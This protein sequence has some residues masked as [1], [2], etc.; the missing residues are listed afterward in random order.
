MNK[1]KKLAMLFLI[2]ASL[3]GAFLLTN[4]AADLQGKDKNSELFKIE[5]LEYGKVNATKYSTTE[6]NEIVDVPGDRDSILVKPLISNASKVEISSPTDGL[7]EYQGNLVW[8]INILDKSK[9]IFTVSVTSETQTKK[10]L[11]LQSND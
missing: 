7:L 6:V 10:H 1:N 11:R 8:K 3:I 5:F 4:C 9:N 2:I